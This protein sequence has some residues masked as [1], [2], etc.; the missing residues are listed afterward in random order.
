MA[1]LHDKVSKLPSKDFGDASR[2]SRYYNFVPSNTKSE[3]IHRFS[4]F[5]NFKSATH[6]SF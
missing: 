4:V 5:M 2:Y 6:Y 3:E 1:D